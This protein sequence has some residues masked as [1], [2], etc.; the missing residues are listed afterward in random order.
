MKK[1]NLGICKL[2]FISVILAIFGSCTPTVD[3]VF[4]SSSS[5]RI[6]KALQ[7]YETV[8]QSAQ[9]G[10]LMK[11]YPASDQ[12]YGGYNIIVKFGTDG[13]ATLACDAFDPTQTSTSHYTLSQSAGPVITF[14]EYNSILHYFSNPINPDNIGKQGQ[15][16]NGD[17]EFTIREA[18]KDK[19][20]MYGKK[21]NSRI[22]MVPFT[23]SSWSDYLKSITTLEAKTGIYAANKYT[24]GNVTADI[25][26]N[27][28]CMVMTYTDDKGA[29][30]TKKAPYIV[31]DKGFE[32]YDTLSL[33]GVKVKNLIY[34]GGDNNEFDS[35]AGD[36]KLQGVVVPLSK[37][38]LSGSIDWYF[39]Y[40]NMGEY[41]K[42]F[43][44]KG[45]TDLKTAEGETL[46]YFVLEGSTIYFKSGKW[47]G[48]LYMTATQDSDD[49][50]TL[51][52]VSGDS[53]GTYYYK[54]G[55]MQYLLFPISKGTDGR[56]FTLSTDNIK[57]PT[58]IILT[59]KS[60]PTNV[61]KVMKAVTDPNS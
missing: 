47:A 19:V 59:D 36:A 48:K 25:T 5:A 1:I 29:T 41:G 53:N 38:L 51:K 28:R 3:D 34:K 55:Y 4:E 40:S 50:V 49:T 54:Y 33:G 45:M 57:N 32:F 8:L 17:F 46:G 22:E 10:W 42:P 23:G 39:S 37:L 61:F 26:F 24:A 6:T 60:K 13:N 30:V 11:Y 15:G 58:S 52:Y 20:V 2:L 16:M 7:D 21:T 18:T 12:Q 56:T 31:T 27:Y 9:N 35:E 44:E 14:D 43:W